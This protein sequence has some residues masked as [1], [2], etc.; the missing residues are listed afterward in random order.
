MGRP[1]P[2]ALHQG[3]PPAWAGPGAALHAELRPVRAAGAGGRAVS[4][5]LGYGIWVASLGRKRTLRF[6]AVSLENS[7]RRVKDRV[8]TR[9]AGIIIFFALTACSAAPNRDEQ[10]P[11]PEERRS[12]TPQVMS[13]RTT[14]QPLLKSEK[15]EQFDVGISDYEA[16]LGE[17]ANLTHPADRQL[18]DL[19]KS[20]ISADGVCI[21]GE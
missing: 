20:T 4:A 19:A 1:V 13:A 6:V 12:E 17:R 11:T 15:S 2:R 5:V 9:L 3:G 18:C 7:H 8:M 21:L 10:A 16:C 14:C